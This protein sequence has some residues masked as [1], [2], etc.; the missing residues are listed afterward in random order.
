MNLYLIKY[1]YLLGII[2]ING[3]QK[4]EEMAKEWGALQQDP[5]KWV[6]ELL[7]FCQLSNQRCLQRQKNEKQHCMLADMA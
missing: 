4:E 5:G 3:Q 6:P 2:D 1:I 7:W